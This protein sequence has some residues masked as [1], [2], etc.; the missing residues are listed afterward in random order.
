[1]PYMRVMPTT[2]ERPA[3]THQFPIHYLSSNALPRRCLV[4]DP[5]CERRNSWAS[6]EAESG[7]FTGLVNPDCAAVSR[8]GLARGDNVVEFGWEVN[9]SARIAGTSE[10]EVEEITI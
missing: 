7:T 4:I 8:L 2:V 5:T 6:I 9:T 10:L 3:Q 1:M